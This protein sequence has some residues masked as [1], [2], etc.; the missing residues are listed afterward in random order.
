MAPR[1]MPRGVRI[2]VARPR[3]TAEPVIRPDRPTDGVLMGGYCTLL[4]DGG[5]FRLW[6]ESYLPGRTKDEEVQICYAES[7]NG[8]DWKKPELGLIEFNGS[9][10]NNLVYSNGHGATIFIDPAAKPAERYKLVHYDKVAMQENRLRP[11]CLEP[12]PRTASTGRG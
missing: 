9:K 6:Y 8:Y 1:F 10:A 11:S 3:L 2:G 5:R 12:F 4:K 7:D